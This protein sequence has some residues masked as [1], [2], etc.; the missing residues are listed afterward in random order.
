MIQSR[1]RKNYPKEVPCLPGLPKE[2]KRCWIGEPL[3]I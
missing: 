1:Q 2:R 3:E